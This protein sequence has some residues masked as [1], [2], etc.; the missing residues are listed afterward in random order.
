MSCQAE[1]LKGENPSAA[2]EWKNV[3][4]FVCLSVQILKSS[5]EYAR[6]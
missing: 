6:W 2:V 5:F 4:L 1:E 3:K